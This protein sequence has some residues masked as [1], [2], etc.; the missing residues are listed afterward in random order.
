[1]D[2]VKKIIE[3]AKQIFLLDG[4]HAPMVFIKG[5]KGKVV[6]E[7]KNFGDNSYQRELAMLN[8]GTHIACKSNVGEL[9]LI[10]MVNEAWMSTDLTMLPSQNP[11]RIEVLS[12]NFLDVISQ[13]EKATGFKIIRDKLGKAVDLR[14]LNKSSDFFEAKGY[15]LPAFVH[16]YRAIS[17]VHN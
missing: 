4:Y 13:E 11:K 14:P 9:D 17:P 8:L 6:V 15:L 7:I 16:G 12:I 10:V 5:D 1:V 3:V 2:E